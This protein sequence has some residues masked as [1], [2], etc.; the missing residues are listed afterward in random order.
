M[1]NLTHLANFPLLHPVGLGPRVLRADTAALAAL[2]VL[3]ALAGDWRET[4]GERG[5]KGYSLT[6]TASLESC[7]DSCPRHLRLRGEPITDKRQLVE[8]LAAGSKPRA[9]M[10]H[11]HRAREIR[12][13]PRRPAPRAL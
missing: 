5:A 2:A 7:P 4:R 10:A 1:R 9:S 8:Y 11:R 6:A 13:P 12:L 3:Q